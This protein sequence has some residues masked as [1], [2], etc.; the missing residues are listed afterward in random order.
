MSN[1]E[2]MLPFNRRN[3]KNMME[4]SSKPIM[5]FCR[6]TD[7]ILPKNNDPS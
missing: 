1:A 5:D 7:F 6:A 3:D 2:K 4:F